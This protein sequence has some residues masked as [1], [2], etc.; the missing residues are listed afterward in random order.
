MRTLTMI[1]LAIVM[2]FVGKSYAQ[3]QTPEEK[4]TALTENMQEQIGFSDETYKKVYEVNLTFATKTQSLKTQDLSKMKKFQAL[5]DLDEERD[6]SLKQI[7]TEDEY[8]AF[9]DHKKENRKTMKEKFK[10]SRS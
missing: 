10:A 1:F 9:Q 5:K 8:D 6:T 4:A 7:L 2:L 3:D